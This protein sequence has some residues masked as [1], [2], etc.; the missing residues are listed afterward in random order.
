MR[1]V[2]EI[3]IRPEW[4]VEWELRILAASDARYR[5]IPVT[6]VT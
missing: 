1:C 4:P 5:H 3:L 6:S 2:C